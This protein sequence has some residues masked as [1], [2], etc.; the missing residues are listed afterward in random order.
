MQ[1]QISGLNHLQF[2]SSDTFFNSEQG[3]HLNIQRTRLLD[4][5]ESTLDRRLLPDLG[6]NPGLLQRCR[7]NRLRAAQQEHTRSHGAAYQGGCREKTVR[8]SERKT[9]VIINELHVIN[10]E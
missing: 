8:N 1:V 6:G 4:R 7:T 5:L 3:W 2:C 10:H 9:L